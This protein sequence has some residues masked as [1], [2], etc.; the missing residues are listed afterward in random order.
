MKT[1]YHMAL[2]VLSAVCLILTAT[3]IITATF[4][5]NLQAHAQ[6]NQQA[7]NNG[8]LGQQGQQISS[9]VLKDLAEAATTNA[10]IRALLE[11]HGYRLQSGS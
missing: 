4:N 10:N 5:G 7:F 6:A 3:L 8:I 9:S 11:K 2:W 1:A